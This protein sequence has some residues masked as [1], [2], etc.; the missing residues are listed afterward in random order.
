MSQELFSTKNKT[1]YFLSN[2]L[3][4]EFMQIFEEKLKTVLL[5][6]PDFE[7]LFWYDSPEN[8]LD[9]VTRFNLQVF[10]LAK[11]SM[12]TPD[13]L[14]IILPENNQLFVN[15]IKTTLNQRFIKIGFQ[16]N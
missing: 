2:Q 11:N 4:K 3:K 15:Q 9:A 13:S 14:K 5:N 16:N 1:Q 6:D 8:F 12:V 7:A 10:D